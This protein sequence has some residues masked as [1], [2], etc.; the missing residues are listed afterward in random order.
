MPKKKNKADKMGVG[1][2]EMENKEAAGTVKAINQ[3][4]VSS[5][6]ESRADDDDDQDVWEVG[7]E[8]FHRQA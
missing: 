2:L 8:E 3:T 1:S 4:E 6:V 5:T 7:C